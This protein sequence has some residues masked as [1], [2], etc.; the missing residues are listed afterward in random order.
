MDIIELLDYAKVVARKGG[1]HTL[2]YFQKGVEVDNKQDHSPV[3]IADREAEQVM[4][5]L[6]TKKYPEHGIIGEE[7]DNTNSNSDI[8]WILDPIDGTISFIHGI[9]TYTTLIGITINKQ[10]I[11]GI[12]YAAALDEMADAAIGHG[13]RF[14]GEPCHVREK[15]RLEDCT[16]ITTD[17]HHIRKH[18]YNDA[19]ENLLEKTRYH[20][21]WG[22]AYG[23]MLIA[24][25]RADIMFDPILHIWDAAALL[26]VIKESGG[27]FCSTK[28]KEDIYAGNG[29]S[30][31]PGMKDQVLSLFAK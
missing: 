29:I 16:L 1:E 17:I 7:F 31:H 30:M 10:P 8:Q 5:T 21:T 19:F 22:D 24:T 11:I 3:T 23:H 25:G 18:N 20:R 12:I 14:N 2:K 27:L 6:I 9:P 26:P 13:A 15:T 28:G 4:R